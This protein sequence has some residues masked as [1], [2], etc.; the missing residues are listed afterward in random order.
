[1]KLNP[2]FTFSQSQFWRN[3]CS[4]R[5]HFSKRTAAQEAKN[6][7][8][9]QKM[10]AIEP[11]NYCWGDAI[12]KISKNIEEEFVRNSWLYAQLGKTVHIAVG[13]LDFTYLSLSLFF[14]FSQLTHYPPK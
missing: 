3:M 14:L 12:K 9:E 1:M 5:S 10:S 4:L 7:G 13:N 11:K 6:S 2:I 8:N